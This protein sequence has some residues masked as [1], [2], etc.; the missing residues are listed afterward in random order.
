[1][2]GRDSGTYL[3]LHKLGVAFVHLDLLDLLLAILRVKY[4]IG[5]QHLD[6]I[7]QVPDVSLQ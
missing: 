7:L 6:L 1:M 2:K 4:A 5:F 3:G